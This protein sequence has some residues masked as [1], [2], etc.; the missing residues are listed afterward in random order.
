MKFSASWLKEWLFPKFDISNFHEKITNSGL[1]IEDIYAI[2]NKFTRVVVGEIVHFKNIC[3]INKINVFKI[4]INCKDIITVV[5]DINIYCRIGIKVPVALVGS[6]IFPN[7]KI[8]NFRKIYD[9]VSEGIICSYKELC[10]YNTS[11]NDIIE[12]NSDA[13]VGYDIYK[14]FMLYDKVVK[15]NIT[16]NRSDCLSIRGF[17]REISIIC[18]KKLHKK[19]NLFKFNNN[20]KDIFSIKNLALKHCP[21]YIGRII[22]DVNLNISSPFWMKNK[23]RNCGIDS[24][25]VISDIINYVLLELGQ[26]VN[27]FNLDKITKNIL[28]RFSNDTDFFYIKK[29]K[30]IKLQN[31]YLVVSDDKE[32]ISLAGIINSKKYDVNMHTKNLFLESAYFNSDSV[33]FSSKNLNLST[34]FSNYFIAGID[35]LIQYES[36]EYATSLI[37]KICGGNAGPVFSDKNNINFSINKIL[38]LSKIKVNKIINDSINNNDI[39]NILNKLNYDFKYCNNQW[40]VSVPSWRLDIN[41]EEDLIEDI[42]RIYGYNNIQKKPFLFLS[43]KPNES[44]LDVFLDKSKILLVNKGYHE[45]IS[46][47]FLSSNYKKIFYPNKDLLELLNPMSSDSLFMRPSLYCGLINAVIYNI[48]RNFKNIKLFESGLCFIKNNSNSIS[49]RQELFLSGVLSGKYY[50]DHWDINNKEVDF[51]DLKGDVE[52]ILGL[53]GKLD[54]IE[55]KNNNFLES[56]LHPTKRANIYL[57]NSLIGSIG[58][59]HPKFDKYLNINQNIILFELFIEKLSFCHST[60]V[61]KISIYP[62][63]RRDI[64]IVIPNN[65]HVFDIIKEIKNSSIKYLSEINIFDVYYGKEFGEQYKSISISLILQ[66]HKKT[67]EVHEINFIINQCIEILFNKFKARLRN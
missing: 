52:S 21:K 57:E 36:I 49:F 3:K 26:P 16:P 30:S 63:T 64:S 27:I 14:Y 17:A 35:P 62:S 59:I 28:V 23:L 19:Q 46:Y 44:L 41:I 38:T 42:I 7:N 66:S 13:P 6:N 31:K 67:L 58:E 2:S 9:I 12:L 45:I 4:K 34:N 18:G 15:V 29:D 53:T 37:L 5:S 33:L 60:K 43:V 56:L 22:R 40:F 61:S 10:I 25:D 50:K 47:S 54:F 11:S 8:V 65:I 1:E 39:N 32:I 51:F 55:F 48:K 20:I 24:I